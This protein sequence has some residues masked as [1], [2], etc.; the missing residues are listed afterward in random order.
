MNIIDKKAIRSRAEIR[1]ICA[2]KYLN[3]CCFICFLKTTALEHAKRYA[4]CVYDEVQSCKVFLYCSLANGNFNENSDIDIAV[5]KDFSD[6]NYWELTKKLNR[7]TRN[8]DNRIEPVLL[9]LKDNQSGFL[10][11]VLKSGIKL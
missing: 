7:L 3:I 5:V 10:S 1:K 11:T 2:L 4:V 8:I 6:D 9:Q